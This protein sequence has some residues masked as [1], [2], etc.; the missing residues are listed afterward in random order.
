MAHRVTNGRTDNTIGTSEVPQLPTRFV[1]RASRCRWANLL[2]HLAAGGLQDRGNGIASAVSYRCRLGLCALEDAPWRE[3]A[4]LALRVRSGLANRTAGWPHDA[5]FAIEIT[6]GH[7][8]FA[9]G[10]LLLI[11]IGL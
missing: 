9:A 5:P 7:V 1:R 3:E 4:G 10:H 2:D 6:A 11:A 8:A